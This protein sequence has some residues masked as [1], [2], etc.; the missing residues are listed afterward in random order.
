MLGRRR[1]Y[2]EGFR[3]GYIQGT[4]DEYKRLKTILNRLEDLMKKIPQEEDEGRDINE[5]EYLS[6]EET[7]EEHEEE[8]DFIRCK[9][10]SKTFKN[11]HG[12]KVHQSRVHT[13]NPETEDRF[14]KVEG[15][16]SCTECGEIFGSR[17][18]LN[19][20]YVLTHENADREDTVCDICG[21]SFKTNRGMKIH[22]SNVHKD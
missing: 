5:D 10:C 2:E 19:V 11:L 21:E 4:N 12:L 7:M 3:E 9:H 20:H 6:L 8:N 18:G 13:D 22:R 14:E 1:K 16:Y 15:G 17:K